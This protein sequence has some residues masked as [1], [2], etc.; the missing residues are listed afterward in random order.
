MTNPVVNPAELARR[1]SEGQSHRLSPADV[2]KQI[3]EILGETA[4]GLAAEA[5]QL[6]R[7]HAV[8]H[9]ALQDNEG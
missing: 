8:L 1:A 6:T 7:A 5:E 3:E 2:D 4:E 9:R